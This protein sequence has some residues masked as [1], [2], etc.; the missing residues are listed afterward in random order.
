LLP[1]TLPCSSCGQKPEMETDRPEGRIRDV[2]RAS[3]DCERG[4]FHRW[5][6]SDFAAIRLWNEIMA[7]EKKLQ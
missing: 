7:D 6:V 1:E 2:Y 5:A 4:S 3:C